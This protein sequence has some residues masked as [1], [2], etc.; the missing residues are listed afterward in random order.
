MTL[1][2]AFVYSQNLTTFIIMFILVSSMV[3]KSPMK[4][5]KKTGRA[6]GLLAA[7]AAITPPLY[8]RAG[9][10]PLPPAF[11]GLF[12]NLEILCSLKSFL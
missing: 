4:K 6:T 7:A 10:I 12:S 11:Q 8:V 3:S 5:T 1:S 9:S 2:I